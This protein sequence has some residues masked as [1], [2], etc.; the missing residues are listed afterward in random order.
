MEPN[1]HYPPQPPVQPV[2]N[3]PR[4]ELKR[5]FIPI[6]TGVLGI[7]IG[8]ASSSGSVAPEPA[9]ASTQTTTVT[10]TTTAITTVTAPAASSS[11]APP[12]KPAPATSSAAPKPAP[13]PQP[14]AST[15]QPAPPVAPPEEVY[16][17]NCA[18]A[19]AAGVAPLHTGDPGYRSGLDRD[20]DGIA[21]E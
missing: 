21:C 13:K 11:P 19:R 3:K 16:Y 5:I 1:Y 10:L 2:P 9:T 18:A 4:R 7:I 14:T 12:P 20:D 6:G 8:A 17:A 15:P